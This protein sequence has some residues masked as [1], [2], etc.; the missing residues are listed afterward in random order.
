MPISI[1]GMG[2]MV[3]FA[4]P[5]RKKCNDGRNLNCDRNDQYD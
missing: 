1:I 4:N 3:T 5:F 2:L